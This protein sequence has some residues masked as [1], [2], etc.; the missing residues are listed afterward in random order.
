MGNYIKSLKNDKA[1]L[2]MAKDRAHMAVC[3]L[4]QY[5]N[6]DKFSCGDDLDG[7]VN[8][9]DVKR[10]LIVIKDAIDSGNDHLILDSESSDSVINPPLRAVEP[11]V[12]SG[13]GRTIKRS[14]IYHPVENSGG[15]VVCNSCKLHK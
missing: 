1:Q 14:R 15:K 7:Y 5:L 9:D 12:C 11:M 2:E 4:A 8:V 10:Y 6:S 3:D 13:C